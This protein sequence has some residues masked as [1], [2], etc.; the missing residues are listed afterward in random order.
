M[1]SRACLARV[2]KKTRKCLAYV[3]AI[4]SSGILSLAEH[5]SK[6]DYC[7]GINDR[8]QTKLPGSENFQRHKGLLC[9]YS[10]QEK[11]LRWFV[12]VS[13]REVLLKYFH[14]SVFSGHLGASKTYHK[15]ASN[16]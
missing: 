14:D 6:D 15:I 4:A 2:W 12:L 7:A 3:A 10:K 1:R 5:Q 8:L 9:Y 13:L 16:F 11:R